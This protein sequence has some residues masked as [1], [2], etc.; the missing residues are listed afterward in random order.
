[1]IFCT[2]ILRSTRESGLRRTS[3]GGIGF[4]RDIQR[5]NVDI[6]T[7]ERCD[8]GRCGKSVRPQKDK[9]EGTVARSRKSC[10]KR[11]VGVYGAITL[12][13]DWPTARLEF[14]LCWKKAAAVIAA[15]AKLPPGT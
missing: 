9:I 2:E 12:R 1:M 4:D 10:P 8:A 14:S 3:R 11:N 6:D 7:I 5:S 13:T 15:L